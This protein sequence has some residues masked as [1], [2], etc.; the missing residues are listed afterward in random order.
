MDLFTIGNRMAQLLLDRIASGNAAQ[1]NR[2]I[3]FDSPIVMGNSTAK[4]AEQ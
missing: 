1:P 4:C 2:E 3:R